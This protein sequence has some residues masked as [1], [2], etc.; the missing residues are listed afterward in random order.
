VSEPG[1][2]GENFTIQSAG[3][4][5]AIGC[6][7]IVVTMLF[8][9]TWAPFLWVQPL[10][11]LFVLLKEYVYDLREET[12]ET[13]R[14]STVDALGYLAGNVV[15]WGLLLLAWHLGTWSVG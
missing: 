2:W 3:D 4:H 15:G 5:F 1:D 12:G 9:H 7:A 13:W 14:S 8:V 6:G 10:L 11:V